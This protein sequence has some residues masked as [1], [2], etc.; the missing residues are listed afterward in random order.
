MTLQE[1]FPLY[2]QNS[3]SRSKE[4][5]EP[6]NAPNV[7]M[8][9]CGPTVYS[10]VHIGNVRTFIT[11]DVL[12]RYLTAL[13]YTVRYVR[14]ITDV[15]HIL[16]DSGEDRIAKRA[17]LEK[18]EP[19]EIVQKYTNY[20]HRTMELFNN[21]EPSIEPTATGHIIEQIEFVQEILDNGFAYESNGSV[22]FDVEKY[23]LSHHYGSLSGRKI[24]DLISNTRDLDGQDEKQNPLD[25]AIWKKAEKQHIMR[26][27][28]PWS[29]GFPGWH[30]EC[31]VMS[32]KYLGE[33]FDIH[34]GGMDLKFPHHECEIAQSVAADGNDPVKYWV[35]GNM[36]TMDG[37][38]MS[39]SLG[40]VISVEELIDGTG[41]Y[42]HAFSPMTIRF[43][44]LQAHYSSTLDISEEAL[45]ASEKGLQRLQK[46]NAFLQKMNYSVAVLDQSQDQEVNGLLD[47]CYRFLSDDL[48]TAKCIANLFEL[49][50]KINSFESGQVNPGVLSERTFNRLRTE[51][52]RIKTEILGL[53]A[54]GKNE[55]G[56][57]DEVMQILIDLRNDARTNKNFELSDA[58][59]DELQKRGIQLLDGKDGT[60]YSVE[61]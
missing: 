22:Y 54:E 13:G 15:G 9:V 33:T 8:Y 1:R 27:P 39:K 48:N 55:S 7:G 12:Y 50:S 2:L 40:N 42:D 58:I 36:L 20:F 18:L 49:T 46:A 41:K 32:T 14:N 37:T 11:F 51:F 61:S 17:K 53:E 57:I 23:N 34:G 6:I 43:F 16:D 26:W 10:E 24:E 25:F 30:L 38:K 52:D 45:I 31:S 28:S 5:F 19:M 56:K 35:H 4:K 21:L 47:N 59:R 44:M 29:E 3:L 60:S